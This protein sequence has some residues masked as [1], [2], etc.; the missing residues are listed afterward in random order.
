[1]LGDC[2]YNE[3]LTLLLPL[4]NCR[5]TGLIVL[6]VFAPNEHLAADSFCFS[7]AMC[8]EN[9]SD[10]CTSCSYNIIIQNPIDAVGF[11]DLDCTINILVVSEGIHLW[12][13][14]KVV[15]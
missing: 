11:L 7:E 6:C 8:G 4:T 12:V 9:E 2:N 3:L 5:R 13:I 15:V 10:Y 14:L 1:M